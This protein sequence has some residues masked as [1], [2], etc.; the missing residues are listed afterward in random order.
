LRNECAA[1]DIV[2]SDRKLP[3]WC[4]PKW[5]RADRVFLAKTG[6]LAVT[7]AGAKVETVAD[8]EGAHP[9]VIARQAS[10]HLR[11]RSH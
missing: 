8:G 1:A 7:L 3:P 11:E 9:W 10:A 4:V 6:G 2:V 5:L